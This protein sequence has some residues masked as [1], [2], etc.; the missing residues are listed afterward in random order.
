MNETIYTALITIL[1]DAAL[2]YPIAYPGFDFNPPTGEAWLEVDFMPDQGIDE[3]LNNTAFIVKQGLFQI[4]AYDRPNNG[5]ARL[6]QVTQ[7]I[8]DLYTRGTILV[9]HV[10]ITPAPYDMGVMRMDDKLMSV[11]TIA[12]SG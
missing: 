4:T 11:V 1:N 3:G 2:S 5:I 10:R 12:Y 8:K 7:Q 9:D 6:Q